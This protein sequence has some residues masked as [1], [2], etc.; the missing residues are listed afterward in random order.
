MIAGKYSVSFKAAENEKVFK[1]ILLSFWKSSLGAV[2]G[3]GR[4]QISL[5]PKNGFWKV[6]KYLD[7]AVCC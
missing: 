5:K 4:M 7:D 2:E 3:I 1:V 6:L